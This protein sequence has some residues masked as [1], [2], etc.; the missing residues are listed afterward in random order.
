[1]RRT[2]ITGSAGCCARTAS[3]HAAALP[4]PAMRDLIA[5]GLMEEVA[6]SANLNQAYKRVKANKGAA[7]VDGMSISELLPWIGENREKL[8]GRAAGRQ[9]PTQNRARGGNP[10][11]RRWGSA[12]SASRCALHNAPCFNSSWGM[13]R[14][15]GKNGNPIPQVD[16]LSRR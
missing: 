5:Q 8:I 2:P 14:Q 9:L 15:C 7:G 3:G 13:V 10:Q 16:D 6:S 1:V 4:S 12:N 11:A